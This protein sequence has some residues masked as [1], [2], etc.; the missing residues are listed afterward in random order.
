MSLVWSSQPYKN[1]DKVQNSIT[2]KQAHTPFWEKR[3][4]TSAT[5]RK[6]G[7]CDTHTHA[8]TKESF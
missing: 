6:D 7:E 5:N 4:Y 3:N 1:E 2:H 8:R